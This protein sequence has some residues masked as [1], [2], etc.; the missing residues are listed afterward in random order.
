MDNVNDKDQEA[1]IIRRIR[2]MLEG[3]DDAANEHE[4]RRRREKAYELLSKYGLDE[5][6]ARISGSRDAKAN[7]MVRIRVPIKTAAFR[8]QRMLLLGMIAVALHTRPVIIGNEMTIVGVRCHVERVKMIYPIIAVQM[9]NA[10]SKRL[11]DDPFDV[12]GVRR[13]R[14][15]FM[16]G[17]AQEAMA[18]I[19]EF[20][21]SAVRG[22]KREAL[23]AEDK[24]RTEAAF[25]ALYPNTGKWDPGKGDAA[26]FSAGSRGAHGADI[27]QSRMGGGRRAIGS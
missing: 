26:G 5:S 9:I 1:K 4:A 18:R 3:A 23:I 13:D 19:V 25:N 14:I 27:G 24:R 10:A 11:P 21:N 15:G 17:Y 2:A 6:D 8:E 22:T 20:E 7:E 16:T 12:A